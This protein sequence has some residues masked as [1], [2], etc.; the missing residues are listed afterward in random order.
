[1]S[2][3]LTLLTYPLLIVSSSFFFRIGCLSKKKTLTCHLQKEYLDTCRRAKNDFKI[4]MTE[5]QKKPLTTT[6]TK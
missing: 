4:V 2:C 1:M 5:K 3:L 6:T